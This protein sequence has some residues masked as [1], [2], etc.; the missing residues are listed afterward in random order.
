MR[1]VGVLGACLVFACGQGAAQGGGNFEQTDGGG[2]TPDS[3]TV[4][5]PDSGSPDAGPPDA[6]PPD[7]GDGGSIGIVDPPPGDTGIPPG[8]TWTWPPAR[9]G[10]VNPIVAENA[11]TGDPAWQKGFTNAFARQIEGYADRVSAKAGDPVNLMVRSAGDST[12]TWTLYRL[13]WYGGA[14]ARQII[15][16]SSVAVHEMPACTNEKATGLVQCGWP[17]A[18]TITIPS[19]AVSGLYIVRIVRQDKIGVLIPV[20]VKDDR[21]SDLYFQSSVTTAQAYNNWGGEG[22]YSDSHDGLGFAVKVSFDRP[23]DGNF[24]SGQVLWYE[25]L[26]ARFLERYGYDVSYTTNLDVSREGAR[27]LLARGAFLSVGHDEYWSGRERIAVQAARDAGLPIFFF[28]ANAAYWKTR[29]EAPGV[30]GTAR[31]VTC[32]KKHPELDPLAGTPDATARYRD[33]PINEPEEALTGAMYESWLLFGEPWTVQNS[34]DPLYQGTGLH[35]GDTIPQLVGNEYDRTFALDTPAPVT[36]V[37]HSPMIDAEGK[38]GLQQATW[39]RTAKGSFV[40]DAGTEYWSRFVDG[41]QEDQRVQRM[42]ANALQMG[43]GLPVPQALLHVTPPA[44]GPAPV[45]TWATSVKTVATGM[46]GP[47]GVA[48]L[49]DGSFVVVDPLAERIWRV[50]TTGSVSA[51]AGDGNPDGNPRFDNVPGL[52]ARFFQPTAL[53]ADKLGNVYVADTHNNA[54]RKIGNDPAHTVTTLAGAFLVGDYV[55]GPGSQARFLDPMGMDFLDDTH[56]VIADSGNQA[57]RILDLTTNAVS[58]LA[59]SHFGDDLDGPA[60]IATF[61]YPTAVAVAPDKRV[62]FLASSTGKLKVIGNDPAHTVTTLVSA[63]VGF[64]DGTGDAAMLE[65]QAGLVWDAGKL[66]VADTL[67]QRLRIVTPGVDDCTTIVRTWAGDGSMS[68]RDGAA[69]TASFELPLGMTFGKDGLLYVVDGAAGTLR[70]V[71]P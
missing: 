13:G 33:D 14:G 38:P 26:M 46:P 9:P 57:I 50:D 35:D 68:S 43:R 37:S 31:I 45:G 8:S 5:Q 47:T 25:A 24:G 28:G 20:V 61:Y 39:Y 32:Y 1:W 51:Y 60:S 10:Y 67:N 65:P 21:P 15:P 3:G 30:D 11:K 12:A 41:P 62:F 4:G 53:L 70:A 63:G 7:A 42:T 52:Q 36:V 44:G 34:T 69:S 66:I 6:G 71:L 2:G 29:E 49:P 16:P 54:I 27:G 17:T 56:I 40:F 64:A 48:Q 55:D 18:F 23:Y 22:L 19:D 59:V 58:T